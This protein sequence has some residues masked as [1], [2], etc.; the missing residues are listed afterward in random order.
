MGKEIITFGNTEIE[1]TRFHQYKNLVSIYYVNIDR[2]VVSSKAPLGKKDFKET[3]CMSFLMKDNKLLEKQ[4]EIWDKAS[5]FIEKGFD[6]EPEYN[7]KY[8]KIKIKFYEGK[9]NTNF[10]FI[11]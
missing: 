4:I 10:L 1:K 11:V 9:S 8:L 5:K 3:K 2:I 7:E 6:S